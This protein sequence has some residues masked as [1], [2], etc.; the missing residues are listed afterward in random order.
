MIQSG[1]LTHSCLFLGN[2]TPV[3]N[4]GERERE[5]RERERGRGSEREGERGGERDRGALLSLSCS[6][7]DMVEVGEMLWRLYKQP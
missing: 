6:D 2:C 3:E 4:L 5:R 7:L 1:A